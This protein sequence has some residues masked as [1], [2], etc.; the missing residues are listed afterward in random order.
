MD[1]I[2]TWFNIFTLALMGATIW[3]MA[4]RIRGRLESN[5][6]L[7]YY[8]GVIAYYQSFPRG[9]DPYWVFV[10]LVC[11]TLLRF[12]FM[13]G[14]ILTLVRVVEFFFFCYVLW[15]AVQLLLGWAW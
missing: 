11:G 7:F 14:V 5:W 9:L 1:F 8:V 12:E 6:P 2:L 13:G 3:V 4:A 10:G 15:R